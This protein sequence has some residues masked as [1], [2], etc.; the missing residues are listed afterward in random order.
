M[1]ACG[2]EPENSFKPSIYII[3]SDAPLPAKSRLQSCP[4]VKKIFVFLSLRKV[5]PPSCFITHCSRHV[6]DSTTHISIAMSIS[7]KT[8][9]I[10][11][12]RSG[13]LWQFESDIFLLYFPRGRSHSEQSPN[14][15]PDEATVGLWTPEH[16]LEMT[17]NC[18]QMSSPRLP[19]TFSISSY[20]SL[21]EYSQSDRA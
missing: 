7:P 6:Q 2:S 19:L 4:V 5:I 11:F 14:R 13:S 18:E 17:S 16:I 15:G 8:S 1:V 10:V 9:A 12:K 20:D 21:M 3:S